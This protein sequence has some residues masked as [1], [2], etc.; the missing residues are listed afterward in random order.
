MIEFTGYLTGSAEKRLYKRIVLF[1]QNM[2]LA[3]ILLISF[4]LIRMTSAIHLQNLTIKILAGSIILIPLIL[5]LPMSEKE[6]LQVKPK[7]IYT[8]EDGYLICITDKFQEVR[9]IHDVKCVYDRGEYYELRFPFGKVS[10]NYICQKSLLTQGSIEE[11]ESLFGDKI[12]N[13][14]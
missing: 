8:T 7:R 12:K 1:R 6:K 3:S 5:R 14:I 13:K 2:L 10:V 9:G 11:F 4:P